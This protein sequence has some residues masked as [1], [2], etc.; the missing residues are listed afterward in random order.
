MTIRI[1]FFFTARSINPASWGK[2]KVA[3]RSVQCLLEQEPILATHFVTAENEKAKCNY[4]RTDEWTDRQTDGRSDTIVNVLR[5]TLEKEGI[6]G[7]KLFIS[8]RKM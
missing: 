4:G 7:M 2:T 1:P 3:S 8:I 5:R 6:F